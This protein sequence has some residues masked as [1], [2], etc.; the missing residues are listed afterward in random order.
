MTISLAVASVTEWAVIV[1]CLIAFALYELYIRTLGVRAPMKTARSAHAAI[2]SD[3]VKAVMSRPGTEILV[4]QTLRNSVMA[5]SFMAT[6]AVLAL[7]GTLTLSGIGAPANPLW[8]S[9]RAGNIDALFFAVKLLL[10]AASFFVSFL[11]MAMAVRFFNH[12]GYVITS[13]VG[14]DASIRM[15][16]LAIAY[17]NRAGHH[18]SL[19][20]RAFFACVPFLA[21]LFSTYLMLPA[22]LLLILILYWFD[23]VPASE[24]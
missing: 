4:I 8:Q 6:T 15:Q 3:W 18:Y 22:T 24:H 10:L 13:Q 1:A 7:S 17:L 9:V 20:L 5:A 12:A 23:R 14:A 2:R 19:G 21:G 11:F 16:A